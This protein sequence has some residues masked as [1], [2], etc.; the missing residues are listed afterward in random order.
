[1]PRTV[2]QNEETP[3]RLTPLPQ[4]AMESAVEQIPVQAAPAHREK[5][6]P[7]KS[8]LLKG[9]IITF[10]GLGIAG[11]LLPALVG[12]PL[13]TLLQSIS[14][15]SAYS[16]TNINY[17][18]GNAA[19]KMGNLEAAGTA[20]RALPKE[21]AEA[22]EIYGPLF[23]KLL[24]EKEYGQ[25]AVL[26]RHFGTEQKPIEVAFPVDTYNVA[27]RSLNAGGLSGHMITNLGLQKS[28]ELVGQT[29]SL[30]AIRSELLPALFLAA[31][32][33]E[34]STLEKLVPTLQGQERDALL[35]VLIY[36]HYQAK[37]WEV[38][39][40][41]TELLSPGIKVRGECFVLN[42]MA[43]SH[44]QEA[45]QRMMASQSS[46]G[47]LKRFVTVFS[48]LANNHRKEATQ[49]QSQL[50]SPLLKDLATGFMVSTSGV[51]REPEAEK[52]AIEQLDS[53][54]NAAIKAWTLAQI[55]AEQEFTQKQILPRFA[56]LVHEHPELAAKYDYFLIRKMVGTASKELQGQYLALMLDPATKAA[57]RK[58]WEAGKIL[59]KL[60]PTDRVLDDLLNSLAPPG[61]GQ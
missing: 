43:L 9:G 58:D 30:M 48:A 46:P 35:G 2:V 14:V 25:A 39:L 3:I 8:K 54:T 34:L 5:G 60:L 42:G 57:V 29:P 55:N 10:A 37:N 17:L 56:A 6:T 59:A 15:K 19:L 1:M 53:Q 16:S 27:S 36:T 12:V 47:F 4:G 31:A 45:V 49:L 33:K 32:P 44:P 21:S 18:R 61:G 11:I 24:A 40:H 22:R 50:D 7:L 51:V 38:A 20:L 13:D 26:L 52:K 41:E 23:E 28:M